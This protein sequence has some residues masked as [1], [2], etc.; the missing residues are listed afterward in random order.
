M[1]SLKAVVLDPLG[2]VVRATIA[3]GAGVA[4]VEKPAAMETAQSPRSTAH[5]RR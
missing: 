5:D 3:N 2:S 1:E 4:I